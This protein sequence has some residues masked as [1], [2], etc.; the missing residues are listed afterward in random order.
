MATATGC[1]CGG[2]TTAAL[3]RPRLRGRGSVDASTCSERRRTAEVSGGCCPSDVCVH[4]VLWR[5]CGE[6]WADKG[7]HSASEL[8]AGFRASRNCSSP[9]LVR[10]LGRGGRPSAPPPPRSGCCSFPWGSRMRTSALWISPEGGRR[11][12]L[13]IG[14]PAPPPAAAPHSCGLLARTP[15]LPPLFLVCCSPQ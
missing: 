11:R 6:T 10:R 3:L 9:L 15:L 8:S 14:T 5:Q 2:E 1:R 12:C 13:S 7:T 4:S